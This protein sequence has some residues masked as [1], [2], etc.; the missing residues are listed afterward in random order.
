MPSFFISFPGTKDILGLIKSCNEG[1]SNIFKV[2]SLK[3]G[4]LDDLIS[5]G[6]ELLKQDK[7]VEQITLKIMDYLQSLTTMIL[8]VSNKPVNE[9]IKD[10]EWNTLRYRHDKPLNTILESIMAEI[11]GIDSTLKQKMAVYNQTKSQLQQLERKQ[12][13]TLLTKSLSEIV[14]KEDFVIGS[15]YLITILVVVP[16]KLEEEWNSEYETISEMV[17]PRSAKKLAN[18]TDYCLYTVVIFKKFKD[19]F[20]E[21]CSKKYHIRDFQ[22]DGQEDL[23]KEI[24]ALSTSVKEQW[25]FYSDLVWTS[26]IIKK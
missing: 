22:V 14:K 6:D 20:T 12:S 19:S 11:V 15:E 13:G 21:K 16:S 8:Y 7:F 3:V 4:T 17:V 2:P 5:T 9:Y 10:F 26:S 18:D 23:E 24:G 25:V 1:V